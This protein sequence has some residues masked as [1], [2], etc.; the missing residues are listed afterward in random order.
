MFLWVYNR[1]PADCR[2]RFIRPSGE[3]V[4][5]SRNM[6]RESVKTQKVY[7]VFA[8]WCKGQRDMAKS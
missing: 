5:G 8:P 4:M 3:P 7:G 1:S 6:W 2:K